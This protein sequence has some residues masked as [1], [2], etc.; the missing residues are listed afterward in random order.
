[1]SCVELSPSYLAAM[2]YLLLLILL[3]AP[4]LPASPVGDAPP[5]P[6]EGYEGAAEPGWGY[7]Y[8]SLVADL[9]RWRR[10][11]YVWI[12]TIG[13]STQG[14]PIWELTIS[15]PTSTETRQRIY[16][17]ARTH[18]NEVQT[19]RV[20]NALIDRLLSDDPGMAEVRRRLVVHI[21]PM[22]NPDGVELGYGRENAHGLDLERNWDKS[23]MESETAALRR[24]FE[25][26]MKTAA[27]IRLALNLHSAVAC[28]RYFIV[29]DHT[30]TSRPYLRYQI[31]F[32]NGVRARWPDGIAPWD[33]YISWIDETPTHF[34]E[35]WWWM[36]HGETVLALTYEDMNCSSAGNYDSTARAM[37][38][39]IATSLS[40]P[41]S[42]TRALHG[43]PEPHTWV[44]Y[45]AGGEATICYELTEPAD[46]A[47]RIYTITGELVQNDNPGLQAQGE[48][49]SVWL[50]PAPAGLYI[51]TLRIGAHSVTLGVVR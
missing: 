7:P 43:E 49:R 29:H 20:T 14:R 28:R 51:C 19:T 40:L 36:T 32:V 23:P 31:N 50:G 4:P 16:I 25:L 35:S 6:G 24:R 12:D 39:G 18:P 17:H 21:V 46:V 1:M 38:G 10:S 30:G 26:L 11:P 9:D 34:P 5:L 3:L 42:T 37:L 22:L 2:S 15:D 33:Y 47:I 41:T 8:D 13:Q 44:E 27:P 45:G 48:H